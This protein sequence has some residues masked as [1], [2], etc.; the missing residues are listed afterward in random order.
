M[1]F[2]NVFVPRASTEGEGGPREALEMCASALNN[3]ASNNTI[4]MYTVV[5]SVLVI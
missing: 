4:L 2:A 1:N 5:S 3:D